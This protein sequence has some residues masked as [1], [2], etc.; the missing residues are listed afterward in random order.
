MAED[1]R[2]KVSKNMSV[3][4][5][6]FFGRFGFELDVKPG[7]EPGKVLDSRRFALVKNDGVRP[8]YQGLLR[9]LV[10]SVVRSQKLREEIEEAKKIE[11]EQQAVVK[12]LTARQKAAKAANDN[13]ALNATVDP[14]AAANEHLAAATAKVDELEERLRT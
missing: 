6:D 10:E 11:K 13:A 14:L 2:R 8:D 12:G 1:F 5:R 9:G 4:A 7:Y 3:F